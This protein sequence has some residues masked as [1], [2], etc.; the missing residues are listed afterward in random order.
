MLVKMEFHLTLS[1]LTLLPRTF[2][3]L[4]GVNFLLPF[5]SARNLKVQGTGDF[6]KTTLNT[7]WMLVP[8]SSSRE[9]SPFHATVGLLLFPSVGEFQLPSP[10]LDLR[11]RSNAR[12]GDLFSIGWSGLNK[13]PMRA[14]HAQTA[15]I[16]EPLASLSALLVVLR[17][18]L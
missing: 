10:P 12:R 5:I 17:G 8:L 11:L 3:A 1:S 18:K 2:L 14:V 16:N 7:T 6:V 13:G 9:H 15:R 4:T